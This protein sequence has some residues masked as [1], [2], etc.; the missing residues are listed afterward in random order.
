MDTA[1]CRMSSQSPVLMVGIDGPIGSGKTTL[2]DAICRRLRS[3]CEIAVIANDAFTVEDA[4]FLIRGETL[5][6]ERIRG[7]RTRG[8]SHVAMN[9]SAIDDLKRTIPGLEVILVESDGD[10]LSARFSSALF[11]LTIYVVDVAAGDR[12]PRKGGAGIARSDLLVVNKM[13]LAP[14]VGA[15]LSVMEQEIRKLRGP[16]PY[17]FTNLKTG[18]GIERV[19]ETI[20]ARKSA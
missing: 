12:L 16:L 15:S 5:S 2:I 13:D 4:A 9:L 11:H 18:N 17:A 10:N 8:A 3:R 1:G 19:V 7:V 6:A 14:Y 20:Q